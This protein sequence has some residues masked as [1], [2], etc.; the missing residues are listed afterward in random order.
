[1]KFYK[2][3]IFS[4]LADDDLKSIVEDIHLVYPITTHSNLYKEKI[5]QA[6]RYINY[7]PA[8]LFGLVNP[9]GPIL[10]NFFD[11][12]QSE[13]IGWH[14]DARDDDQLTVLMYPQIEQGCGGEFKTLMK[15]HLPT[16]GSIIVLPS[17]ELH[18]ITSYKHE[19]ISRIS[20][21]WMFKVDK[22]TV[23]SYRD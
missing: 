23:D 10:L 8:Q 20:L 19:T 4:I 16:P 11:S 21:K 22:D 5:D 15:E 18:C 14:T 9:Q 17:N 1:M 12:S 6:L 3:E 13:S 7:I 2:D